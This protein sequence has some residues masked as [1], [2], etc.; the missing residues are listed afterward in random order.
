MAEQSS[1]NDGGEQQS[2]YTTAAQSQ[3]MV[4]TLMGAAFGCL[5]FLRGLFADDNYID[6][7][8]VAVGGPRDHVRLK[9]LVRGRSTEADTLLDWLE[10]GV[11]DALDRRYLKAVALSIYAQADA[12]H[13]ALE[14][15]TF[16]VAY[17]CGDATGLAIENG[18]GE[19]VEVGV[20]PAAVRRSLQAMIR[21]FIV[22]TQDLPPLPDDRYVTLRLVFTET[23]PASYQPP[24]FCDTDGE[25]A[26]HL[27]L[28]ADEELARHHVGTLATGWHAVSVRV[29][30]V[31]ARVP[32][33]GR[34]SQKRVKVHAALDDVT[35]P[36]WAPAAQLPAQ[37]PARVPSRAQAPAESARTPAGAVE[38]TRRELRQMFESP[39]QPDSVL[40]TMPLDS[41]SQ[42]A[43]YMQVQASQGDGRTKAAEW[44]RRAQGPP[45]PPSTLPARARGTAASESARSQ[46][47]RA[48]ADE[49]ARTPAPTPAATPAMPTPAMPA[50]S[51]LLPTA[52]KSVYT[53]SRSQ[54]AKA[55]RRS[56]ST[57]SIASATAPAK[58]VGSQRR[59]PGTADSDED[60]TTCECGN[61][62]D[63]KLDVVQCDDCGFWKHLHCYGFT[64]ARDKLLRNDFHCFS[65]HPERL[66]PASLADLRLLFFFRRTL[67][68]LWLRQ[69]NLRDLGE[70]A[71]ALGCDERE[72]QPVLELLRHERVIEIHDQRRE[73]SRKASAAN[74]PVVNRAAAL[75]R[76]LHS[77]YFRASADTAALALSVART[78]RRAP[79]L[80]P[81]SDD[82]DASLDAHVYDVDDSSDIEQTP[83]H[84]RMD[85]APRSTYGSKE[86]P[87][88][89]VRDRR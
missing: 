35:E 9:K 67:K 33:G 72:L 84:R 25:P 69:Q 11:Y 10:R 83:V 54:A 46:A 75:W 20:E 57:A 53:T 51:R 18:H 34:G 40:D 7:R 59:R 2:A 21:R 76:D 24:G 82:P 74:I 8:F 86:I 47:E 32:D 87:N 19:R 64:N 1:T 73:H 22:I 13:D 52:P 49:R 6:E 15:Y 23:T 14:T 81:S 5:T 12:P 44:A 58:P 45:T 39:C 36:S 80:L 38:Q 29:A 16:S 30:S 56:G 55:R 31:P 48:R 60:I 50:P 62:D 3:D 17:R 68:L 61:V 41:P 70:L 4:Q 28:Y 78:V 77:R 27:R 79:D 37:T 85:A 71:R 89:R 42:A 63:A 88:T 43:P 26:M 65:C 66:A